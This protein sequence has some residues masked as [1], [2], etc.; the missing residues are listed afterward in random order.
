M[1]KGE[2]SSRVT[3]SLIEFL[4]KYKLTKSAALG[5]YI[6][7]FKTHI[8]LVTDFS[9]D[10]VNGLLAL[11]EKHNF[12]IFEDRK[13]VDIGH[14][15]QQQYHNGALR[16]SSWA[17]FVNVSV[18]AGEGI[19]DALSQT[20]EKT[21]D[22]PEDRALLILAELTTRGSL[23]VGEY[24]KVSVDIA[25]KY[26]RSVIGFVAMQ[27]LETI[28]TESKAAVDEDF[29][30]FTTGVNQQAKGDQLGQQY[31]TPSMAVLRGSDFVIAGRGIHNAENPVAAAKSYQEEGWQAYLERSGQLH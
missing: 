13:F 21:E 18:L 11:S 19:V 17:H 27:S 5:P 2:D 12:M 7:V 4:A 24:T 28:E 1:H 30:V 6:A 26:P 3:V 8:D 29:V 16:I 15:V 14:T 31:Q 23:A 9:Q 10:T 22:F 25:R 20:I